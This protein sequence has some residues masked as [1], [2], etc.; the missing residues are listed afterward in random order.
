MRIQ[1]KL[2]LVVLL[3]LMKTT[4]GQY[5]LP[6]QYTW[7]GEVYENLL[8]SMHYDGRVPKLKIAEKEDLMAYAI[9]DELGSEIGVEEKTLRIL[10]EFGDRKKDALA[11]IL[12][13]ELVHVVIQR[14]ERDQ[15]MSKFEVEEALAEQQK[16]MEG[17]ADQLGIL[18]AKIA[19]YDVIGFFPSV[20]ERLYQEYD[21][22]AEMPGYPTLNN[23]RL[24][25]EEL[26]ALDDKAKLYE[27][28]NYYSLLGLHES[29]IGLYEY[30]NNDQEGLFVIPECY[31]NIAVNYLLS[32][33]PYIEAKSPDM[34]Y[35]IQIDLY[36]RLEIVRKSSGDSENS[37]RV[38]SLLE[39]AENALMKA[40]QHNPRYAAAQ[41]NYACLY[42]I[43][44]KYES[45]LGKIKDVLLYAEGE[46]YA[47]AQLMKGIIH[48]H[49]GEKNPAGDAFS[50]AKSGPYILPKEHAK[51]N[52]RKL[53]NKHTSMPR[54]HTSSVWNN[55]K[56]DGITLELI[57]SYRDAGKIYDIAVSNQ[58][59]ILNLGLISFEHSQAYIL[60]KEVSGKEDWYFMQITNADY[61][62][63]SGQGIRIGDKEEKIIS[64]Y[65][66]EPK[67]I[68]FVSEGKALIYEEQGIVFIVNDEHEVTK[69]LVFGTE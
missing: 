40:I 15:S 12:A 25:A 62:G 30:I 45:A 35:P 32:A 5:D 65:R 51:A 52:I 48:A 55:E 67:T 27:A 7:V 31:N 6:E 26:K 58:D 54:I 33:L 8:H 19:G 39:G 21:L 16:V 4:W 50:E 23:R 2:A 44:S 63:V 66:S 61:P 53:K 47:N 29:A 46:D 34:V 59:P 1:R 36:S 41:I 43:E 57:S 42:D 18:L 24:S 11:P 17:E 69:W 13:H 64:A 28:A 56:M 49:L 68:R 22:P 3:F 60:R 20:I 9:V 38:R 37:H 10:E 14:K